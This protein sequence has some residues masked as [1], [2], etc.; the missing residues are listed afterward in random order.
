M[1]VAKDPK[2]GM[3][4]KEKDQLGQA[5]HD[6]RQAELAREQAEVA[7]RGWTADANLE[8]MD[9]DALRAEA[10]LRGVT[11]PKTVSDEQARKRL[12]ARRREVE[13][14]PTK[15]NPPKEAS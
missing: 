11:L 4:Q 6:A 14:D 12:A 1:T 2:P 3:G 15:L 5:A 8:G 10:D 13:A 7:M 9:A